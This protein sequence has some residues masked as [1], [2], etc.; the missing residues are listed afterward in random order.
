MALE[1]NS[2]A[3]D[4]LSNNAAA[5]AWR[6]VAYMLARELALTDDYKAGMIAYE[7]FP[8]ALQWMLEQLNESD[9]SVALLAQQGVEE[10]LRW[11]DEH[12]PY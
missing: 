3:Q 4:G 6:A 10:I 7:H 11:Q 9:S 5:T 8:D 12:M 2:A 1:Q